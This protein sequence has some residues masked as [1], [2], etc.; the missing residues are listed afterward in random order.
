MHLIIPIL[1]PTQATGLIINFVD[2]NGE[3]IHTTLNW[4]TNPNAVLTIQE[5]NQKS[6]ICSIYGH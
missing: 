4:L 6:S 1:D 5:F 3:D 2:S